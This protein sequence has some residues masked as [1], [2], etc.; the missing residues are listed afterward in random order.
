MNIKLKLLRLLLTLVL[1][2]LGIVFL[3]FLWILMG[4]Q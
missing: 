4:W 3:S 1:F 2:Y